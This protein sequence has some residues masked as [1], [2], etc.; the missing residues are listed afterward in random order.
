MKPVYSGHLGISLKRPDYQ[1]VLIIQVSLHVMGTLGPLPS[2]PIMEVSLFSR[3]LIN[4]LH[5]TS[6][7]L[8]WNNLVLHNND[9]AMFN[10]ICF[11]V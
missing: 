8:T 1:G 4:R 7:W 10:E 6:L 11:E 5:C 3:A 2:V 9:G